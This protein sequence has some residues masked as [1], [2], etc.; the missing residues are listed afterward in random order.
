MAAGR[1]ENW[2]SIPG[3][4]RNFNFVYSVQNEFGGP[5]SVIYLIHNWSRS[6]NFKRPVTESPSF[7]VEFKNAWNS[8]SI[9]P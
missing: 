6:K 9:S 2:G 5:K 8:T 4:G 1:A 3:G 7:S